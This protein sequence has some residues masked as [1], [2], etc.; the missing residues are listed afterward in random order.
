MF[1]VDG[2]S[3]TQENDAMCLAKK[4]ETPHCVRRLKTFGTA[5]ADRDR[6][7]LIEGAREGIGALQPKSR[8]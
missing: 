4:S 2:R 3:Q 7:G 8:G 6:R 5:R 1:A